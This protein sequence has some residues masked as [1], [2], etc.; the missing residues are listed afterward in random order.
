M[1]VVGSREAWALTCGELRLMAAAGVL[2]SVQG[3]TATAQCGEEHSTDQG[4]KL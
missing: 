1:L 3:Y 2:G 4:T